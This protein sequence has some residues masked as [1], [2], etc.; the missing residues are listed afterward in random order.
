M[1]HDII[2]ECEIKENGTWHVI[3]IDDALERRGDTMRCIACHGP[4]R[5]HKKY[6]DGARAHFEHMVQHTG[7]KISSAF[8]G[9]P[10]LHPA[11]LT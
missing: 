1:A 2:V 7:C 5:P 9:A 4:V 8:G 10:S 3:G 6:S 11:A